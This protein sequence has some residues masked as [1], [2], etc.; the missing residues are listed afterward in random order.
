MML[1]LEVSGCVKED[2]VTCV[3]QEL[4][5]LYVLFSADWPGAFLDDRDRWLVWVEQPRQGLANMTNEARSKKKVRMIGWW[6]GRPPS[7]HHCLNSTL[8]LLKEV[9]SE[10]HVFVQYVREIYRKGTSSIYFVTRTC[11]YLSISIYI[12]WYDTH[13]YI[14]IHTYALNQFGIV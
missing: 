5:F 13:I 11:T 2:V 12:S 6:F 4:H 1:Y 7:F 8:F 3:K 10:L 9:V 14:Y